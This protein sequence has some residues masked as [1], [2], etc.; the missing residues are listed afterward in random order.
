MKTKTYL[1]QLQSDSEQHLVMAQAHAARCDELRALHAT[2][3]NTLHKAFTENLRSR[4][5]EFDTERKALQTRHEGK[6]AGVYEEVEAMQEFHTAREQLRNQDANENHALRN[7][8]EQ[9]VNDLW[10]QFQTALNNY[11]ANTADQSEAFQRWMRK[12]QKLR[13]KIGAMRAKIVGLNQK[14]DERNH[15][16]RS[17]KENLQ[18]QLQQLKMRMNKYRE[19]ENQ[20]LLE[21]TMASDQTMKELR[22]KRE[23]ARKEKVLPFYE[24]TALDGD[25][26]NGVQADEVMP[27]IVRSHEAEDIAGESEF[28][29]RARTVDGKCVSEYSCMNNFWKRYNKILL[30]RLAMT[31]NRDSLANENA[32]LKALLKQYL[33]GISVYSQ[34]VVQPNNTL[35]MVNNHSRLP[36]SVSV[37]D[38]RVKRVQPT[39]VDANTVYRQQQLGPIHR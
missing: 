14:N 12:L 38:P 8:L 2:R 17:E 26:K 11:T 34:T 5:N 15:I 32:K 19:G 4:Q 18:K 23:K 27:D 39:V 7:D 24:D 16:L 1:E 13:D 3:L 10:G 29:T 31:R 22:R 6:H 20:R 28:Q 30:D 37:N 21:L 36:M 25:E 9:Q 33:D 35:L